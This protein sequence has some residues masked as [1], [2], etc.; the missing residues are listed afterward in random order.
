M[1]N[2]LMALLAVV[3]Y[4]PGQEMLDHCSVIIFSIFNYKIILS[5]QSQKPLIYEF[6][7]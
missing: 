5:A 6:K 1:R 3:D 2:H 7:F 4:F